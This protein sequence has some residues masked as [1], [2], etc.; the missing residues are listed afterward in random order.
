V[1][2]GC[3]APSYTLDV[4]GTINASS[5]IFINGSPLLAA[6]SLYSTVR[7]LGSVG[8]VSTTQMNLLINNTFVSSIRGLGESGYIS[9]LTNL[10]NVT[11][12]NSLQ[13]VFSSIGVNCNLPAYR[14]DVNGK[15]N[16]SGNPAFGLIQAQ[17]TTS[18]TLSFYLDPV[19]AGT[20]S[21]TG[22]ITGQT[23]TTGV[24][25]AADITSFGVTRVNN[26]ILSQYGYYMTSNGRFGI[27][28]NNPAANLHVNALDGTVPGLYVSG[29]N[30]FGLI[31]LQGGGVGYG[32]ETGIYSKDCFVGGLDCNSGWY[33]GQSHLNKYW[34]SCSDSRS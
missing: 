22:W 9:S 23:T 30:G 5:N 20:P 7:G 14:L 28:A 24:A 2:I 21:N 11:N 33:Y 34:W 31:Q 27:N 10:S 4:N 15:L 16:I 13:G 26:S 19:N 3:N 25:G 32:Q 17:G 8:Y 29:S 18:E 12:V 1:G 6:S